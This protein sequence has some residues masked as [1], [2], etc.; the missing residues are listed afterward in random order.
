MRRRG[1]ESSRRDTRSVSRK[2]FRDVER[3]RKGRG[4]ETD[5]I[6]AY[7]KRRAIRMHRYARQDIRFH[8]S[9]IRPRAWGSAPLRAQQGADYNIIANYRQKLRRIHDDSWLRLQ[10]AVGSRRHFRKSRNFNKSS[11][12]AQRSR[13]AS[14]AYLFLLSPLPSTI[15][16]FSLNFGVFSLSAK[17]ERAEDKY[18]VL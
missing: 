3:R 8:G 16:P 14:T 18:Q 10:P 9:S 4:R 6:F 1:W 12:P 15:A 17:R 7:E 5:E 13:N 11:W 2:H